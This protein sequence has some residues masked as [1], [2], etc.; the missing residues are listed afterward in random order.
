MSCDLRW[1]GQARAYV[2]FSAQMFS[3]FVC[4]RIW[5]VSRDELPV[6][7]GLA[8]AILNADTSS[9]FIAR[10]W[11]GRLPCDSCN[12]CDCC[13]NKVLKQVSMSLGPVDLQSLTMAAQAAPAS[14]WLL[15]PTGLWTTAR[16]LTATYAVIVVMLC[17]H[18]SSKIDAVCF[19]QSQPL[20]LLVLQNKPCVLLSTTRMRLQTGKGI[21]TGVATE[22]SKYTISLINM[23]TKYADHTRRPQ[24]SRQ[25]VYRVYWD[26]Q[27]F[28]KISW[29]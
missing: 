27:S 2:Q 12:C 15:H 3:V 13:N 17:D 4:A 22:Q 26:S 9:L 29:A 18:N 11:I 14:I 1:H 28:F 5:E 21:A 19:E 6:C 20:S 24:L 23:C 8:E 25:V 7:I 16:T 10:K